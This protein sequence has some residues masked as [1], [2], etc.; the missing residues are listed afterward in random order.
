MIV[1]TCSDRFLFAEYFD[2]RLI[3]NLLGYFSRKKFRNFEIVVVH[4]DPQFMVS[5]QNSIQS[6]LAL[7]DFE[8]SLLHFEVSD[9]TFYLERFLKENSELPSKKFDYIEYNGGISMDPSFR[10]HLNLFSGALSADGVIGRVYHCRTS[11]L[12]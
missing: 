10:T 12:F 2:R 7:I 4:R 5:I 3:F 11:S 8:S 1:L 9:L 6:C